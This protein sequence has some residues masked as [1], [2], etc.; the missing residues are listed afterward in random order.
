M[1]YVLLILLVPLNLM[2]DELL[3]GMIGNNPYRKNNRLFLIPPVAIV[4]LAALGL[5]IGAVVVKSS[6]SKFL[7]TKK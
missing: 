1:I 7:K 4:V 5:F 2:A 6:I 3:N